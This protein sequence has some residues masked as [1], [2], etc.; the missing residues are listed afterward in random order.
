[1]RVDKETGGMKPF[2]M[3]ENNFA[4]TEINSKGYKPTDETIEDLLQRSFKISLAI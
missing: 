2:I 4:I 3:K 1:M